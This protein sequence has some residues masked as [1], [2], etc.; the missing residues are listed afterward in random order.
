MADKGVDPNIPS[1]IPGNPPLITG[2]FVS[3]GVVE[4]GTVFEPT[5]GNLVINE[6]DPFR[7]D[8]TW[9]MEG[10]LT[11]LWL[12]ALAP[13]PPDTNQ[14]S[15]SAY[16]ESIGPGPELLLAQENVAVSTA[17][18]TGGANPPVFTWTHSLTVNPGSGL[19]EENPGNPAG[20][21]GVYKLAATVFL[22][23][24]LGAPGFDVIGFIE[25]PVIKVENPL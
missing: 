9:K 4:P 6:D 5:P 18:V 8:L 16:A 12:A 11:P 2:D 15:V 17:V 7:I 13:N 21:S 22:N 19:L 3:I 24:N 14:W 1:P 20:P 25:G 23:S 10:P